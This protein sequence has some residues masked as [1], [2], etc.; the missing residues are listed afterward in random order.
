MKIP[1]LMS[2]AFAALL[3]SPAHATS[4]HVLDDTF[5]DSHNPHRTNGRDQDVSVKASSHSTRRGFLR[6]DLVT[7]PTN[8]VGLDVESASLKL[9]VGR[10]H[11]PDESQSTP[12]SVRGMNAPFRM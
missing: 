5:A 9:W 10:V 1:T 3:A 12:F 7:L 2:V 6:F 8:L 11:R 4:L